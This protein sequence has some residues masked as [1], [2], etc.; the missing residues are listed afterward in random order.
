MN[1]AT[2]LTALEIY[3]WIGVATAVLFLLFGIDR[4]D[5]SARGS[6]MFRPIL[7]PGVIVVWPLVLY[8]WVCLERMEDKE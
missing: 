7:V 5:P 8:R 3:G 1:P 4:I 6:Y 2:L